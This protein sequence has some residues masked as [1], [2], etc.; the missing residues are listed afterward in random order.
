[1]TK[2]AILR[3]S[4]VT[5]ATGT[6]IGGLS[7]AL[8]G[9]E[10]AGEA[11]GS[12][13]QATRVDSHAIPRAAQ[14]RG[15]SAA[16]RASPQLAA[17]DLSSRGTGCDS[18]GEEAFSYEVEVTSDSQF[19]AEALGLP[20]GVIPET[21]KQTGRFSMD[22]LPVGMDRDGTV[23]LGAFRD[24]SGRGLDEPALA[25]PFLM[26]VGYDCQVRA[27]A[28]H[29]ST[30]RPIG[31]RQQALL[32]SLAWRFQPSAP[33]AYH[34]ANSIGFFQA[35]A[36]ATAEGEA[37]VVHQ[38][39]AHYERLWERGALGQVFELVPEASEVTVRLTDLS[40]IHI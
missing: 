24:L 25:K 26:R 33:E 8:R 35:H 6:L 20:D 18:L 36:H 3:W 14:L 7:V 19:E 31:R 5:V 2:Q 16:T 1:M 15:S 34:G 21:V 9:S 22:L 12:T 38:E 17:P 32:F 13:G 40:L 28:H 23:L 39:V 4:L 37:L 29:E 27:F 11:A 30:T 10:P